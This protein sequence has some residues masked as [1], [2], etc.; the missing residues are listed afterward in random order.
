MGKI[1][2]YM[3]KQC[4]FK[5]FFALCM[6]FMLV[7]SAMPPMSVFANQQAGLNLQRVPRRNVVDA[8]G[9]GTAVVKSDG[10]LWAWGY[11]QTGRPEEPMLSHVA[12]P[13]MLIDSGVV[14]VTVGHNEKWVIKEDNSLWGWGWNNLGQLGDGTMIERPS[15]VRI[16]DNVASMPAVH[17]GGFVIR[18]DGSLWTWD[19][20]HS[21]FIRPQH[22]ADGVVSISSNGL[23]TAIVQQDGGLYMIGYG[24][25]SG[26]LGDGTRGP[27]NSQRTPVRVMDNVV[28]AHTN[29]MNTIALQAD[30]SLWSWGYWAGSLTGLRRESGMLGDGS[31]T[32]RLRPVKI[33]ENVVTIAMSDSDLIGARAFAVTADGILYGWGWAYGLGIGDATDGIRATPVRIMDNVVSVSAGREHAHVVRTDGS[34]WGFGKNEGIWPRIGDGTTHHAPYPVMIFG[35][36][37]ISTNQGATP[38]TQP[39]PPITPP[40]QPPINEP[41]TTRQYLGVDIRA[42]QLGRGAR[43]FPQARGVTATSFNM[44]GQTYSRGLSFHANNSGFAFY[45]LGGQF[46]TLSGLHGPIDVGSGRG[47]LSIIITDEND[48]ELARLS[49]NIGDLPQPFSIDVT[50]VRQLRITRG[51]RTTTVGIFALADA[52]LE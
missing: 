36:G 1:I 46:T 27:G 52:A 23:K 17:A 19:V 20:N 12:S 47:G 32:D 9:S 37:S 28:E 3:M 33:M 31:T 4:M 24:W 25:E 29:G 43:E 48:R 39:A 40:T 49:S 10:S 41:Q 30:G 26:I 7:F 2:N 8:H 13:I 50:G 45:Y 5:R 11:V 51:D 14:S 22:V 15:P 38:P 18:L 21:D 6:V 44:A 34:L 42:Y 16:L 35:P